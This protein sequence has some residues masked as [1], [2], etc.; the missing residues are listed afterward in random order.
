MLICM[1]LAM[2]AAVV[3]YL[4]SAVSMRTVTKEDMTLIPKGEKLAKLLH[5][6]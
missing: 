2:A 4:V 1:A 3:V 5:M 6:H